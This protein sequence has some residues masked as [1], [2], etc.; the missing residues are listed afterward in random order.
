MKFI[1]NFCLELLSVHENVETANFKAKWKTTIYIYLIAEKHTQLV[2]KKYEWLKQSP[3]CV[4]L[5]ISSVILRALVNGCTCIDL[6]RHRPRKTKPKK[7]L[8]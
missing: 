3:R 8:S 7:I 5:K 1:L 6:T 2:V 4:L